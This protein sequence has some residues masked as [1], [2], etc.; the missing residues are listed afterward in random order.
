MKAAHLPDRGI[1]KIAGDQAR[2][3]LQGLVTA[4]IDKVKPGE[5]RFAALLTPQG[6]IVIDFIVIEASAADGG[7]YFL[8]CPKALAGELT[9]KLNFYKLR[10]K[11]MIQNLSDELAVLATWDGAADSEYG[12]TYADPRLAALGQRT[13]LP[14]DVIEDAVAD[15]AATLVSPEDYDAR[16]IS[17]GVPRGG[18]DF[19]YADAFPHE[20]DMDQLGGVDFDKG[21]YV[22]QEVVSRMQHRGSARSRVVPVTYEGFAP[23]PGTAV[24]AGEKT[25][26]TFGSS[27]HGH[28]LALL[29]L[30]RIEDAIAAGQALRAGGTAFTLVRPDWARF[31]FPGDT[32]AA[33]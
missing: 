25:V 9:T 13:I 26:G 7:G 4:D 19:S 21:C 14:P 6:K 8:D 28:A 11:L 23:E 17:L 20:S 33:E 1:V 18:L 15:L 12:L 5:P 22:G 2:G 31:A 29:R 30:D 16:R 24:M 10:A 3:F 32:K 27:A